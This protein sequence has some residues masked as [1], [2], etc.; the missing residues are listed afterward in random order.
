MIMPKG[1]TRTTIAKISVM[2]INKDDGIDND[3]DGFGL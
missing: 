2:I 1:N 3:D